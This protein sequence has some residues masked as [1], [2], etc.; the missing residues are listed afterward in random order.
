MMIDTLLRQLELIFDG[1]RWDQRYLLS[2]A[3]C[4]LFYEVHQ[5]WRPKL[6]QSYKRL[7]PGIDGLVK[8]LL[9]K[10]R[11]IRQHGLSS[12]DLARALGVSLRDCG[13]DHGDGDGE[14][15]LRQTVQG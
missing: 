11:D 13:C 1:S 6:S 10:S 12:R 3:S 14:L 8:D 5:V 15:P 4:R 9:C 7:C 2:L